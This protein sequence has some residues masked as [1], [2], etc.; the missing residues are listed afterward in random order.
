MGD[1]P[2][3]E[4]TGPT[5][6]TDATGLATKNHAAN[7]GLGAAAFTPAYYARKGGLWADFWTIL[8]PPYTLWNLSFVAMG[9]ALA[10]ALD[11]RMLALMLTAFLAGTGVASHALDELNGRPLRTGFSDRALKLM[12]LAALA[13]SLACALLSLL[14][15]SVWII[16]LALLG[17]LLVA[18]YS[19]EWF[20]GLLHTNLGFALSWG[21]Y[22]VLVGYWAQTEALTPD[23]LLLAAAATLMSL[24]QRELSTPARFLRRKANAG[25]ATFA[26]A[27]GVIQWDMP[28]L[29]NSYERP[30]RLLSWMAPALA[31]AMILAKLGL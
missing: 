3:S 21:G 30:L 16:L 15:V 8:H 12:A 2:V 6:M 1:T 17:A 23:A 10:P 7:G 9:A 13:V 18:A 19:L 31:A 26:T 5:N 29:L 4:T 25:G 14:F 22:P 24:A 11:W 28:R 27:E 20:G